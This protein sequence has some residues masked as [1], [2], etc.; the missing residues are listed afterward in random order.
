MVAQAGAL[1]EEDRF[2]DALDL[3]GSAV[4]QCEG[5]A[6]AHVAKADALYRRGDFDEAERH[7]RRAV[8]I[9]DESP[10]AHYGVGR[11]FRTLGRY[12][13]AGQSFA[14]AAALDPDEPRYLRTL[15]NHL[16]RRED[17]K[18]TLARYIEIVK[19][20]PEL[21][22]KHGLGNVEAWL[23][24]LERAGDEPLS[25]VVKA[26]PTTVP[27]RVRNGQGYIRMN[28]AGLKNQRFV[29]DTGATGMTISPRIARK[30]RL[31][32]IE[33][34]TIAG[35]GAGRTETGDLVLVPELALGD[36][37]IVRNV[38]AT[39]RDAAG[40]EEGLVGPSL[41]ARLP[42]TIDMDGGVLSFGPAG[43]GPAGLALPF[44]NV[45]GEIFVQVQVNGVPF[46]A[47]LDTGS[48]RTIIGRTTVGRLPD[49]QATPGEWYAGTT[50]G[51]GGALAD[52][53]VI[54]KGTLDVAG[55]SFVADGLLSG[56][57]DGISRALES[58]VY[59]ILGVPHLDEFVLTIDYKAMTVTFVA[60]DDPAGRN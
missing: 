37:I 40:P 24:L 51:I 14:R 50:I 43:S 2:E 25:E 5:R 10:G 27:M 58:E 22:R 11:I 55:R 38:H 3:A 46:N 4:E 57:L 7:Y 36:G 26:Q 42:I 45:G 34:Y 54:L 59:V 41:F 17:V 49:L 1:M 12:A 8:A 19:G 31:D 32:P 9:D 6:D 28:V 35:T 23:A 47:M 56:N 60:P 16:A 48:A 15:A 39:V 30:A 33:P 18:K 21:E 29:F 44:R 53:K 52:R 13:E 20:N